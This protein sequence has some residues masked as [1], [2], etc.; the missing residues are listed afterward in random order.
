MTKSSAACRP[1]PAPLSAFA[2][3]RLAA[4]RQAALWQAAFWLAALWLAA[5][6]AACSN[7]SAGFQVDASTAPDTSAPGDAARSDVPRT[8]LEVRISSPTPDAVFPPG[9]VVDLEAEVTWTGAEMWKLDATWSSS[10]AGELGTARPDDSGRVV[11]RNVELG[12]GPQTL[13]IL[14]VA[15]AENLSVSDSVDVFVRRKP[16]APSIRL[17]PSAPSTE[18]PLEVFIDRDSTVDPGTELVYAYRWRRDGEV[19]QGQ[20]E[21]TIGPHLTEK[22]E[23]WEVAVTPLA[24]GVEGTLAR[25]VVVIRNSLPSIRGVRVLPSVATTDTTLRCEPEDPS[26]V[27]GDSVT[28]ERSWRIDGAVVDGETGETLSGEHFERGDRV[29]CALRPFDGEEYGPTVGSEAVV[30]DNSIPWADGVTVTPSQG[31]ASDT[32]TC[33][34]ATSGDADEDPVTF[35]W[36]W[37]LEGAEQPGAVSRTFLPFGASRGQKLACGARP[38]DGYD[39]GGLVR[40]P[41]VTLGNTPPV[42]ENVLVQ[43]ATVTALGSLTCDPQDGFDADGDPISYAFTW[44]V[45]EQIVEGQDDATLDGTAGGWFH[46]D[47][48]VHC[49][50]TPFDGFDHGPS[51]RS[52]NSVHVGNAPPSLAAALIDPPSGDVHTAFRCVANGF[53]DPDPGDPESILYRW[54]QNGTAVAGQV[55]EAY[56]GGLHPDDVLTCEAT[57]FD[58]LDRGAPVVSDPATIIDL[59]P[60]VGSAE[61]APT[62]ANRLSTLRCIPHGWDDPESAPAGYRYAWQV[63]GQILEG[64]TGDALDAMDLRRGNVVLCRV[65]PWDGVQEGAPV[66]SNAVPIGNTPPSLGGAQLLPAFGNHN[67]V[68]HCDPLSPVDLDGDTVFY[69]YAWFHNDVPIPGA[70]TSTRT[71][72]VYDAGDRLRCQLTPSDG[73]ATG[74]PA[75]SNDATLFNGQPSIETVVVTPS[76]AV[77]TNTLTCTVIGLSDPDG[78]QPTFRLN[79]LVNG[80]LVDGETED[81]L[82]PGPFAKHDQVICR[83]TPNDGFQDGPPRSSDPVP[84]LNTIPVIGRATVQGTAIDAALWFRCDAHE[85]VDIDQDP[86][87]FRY[88]WFKNGADVPGETLQI[89]AGAGFAFDDNVQCEVRPHDGEEYGAPVLSP[90]LNVQNTPPEAEILRPDATRLQQ[91]TWIEFEGRVWDI[92][93]RPE[94]LYAWWEDSRVGFLGEA[95]PDADGKVTF[96]TNELE[97][98]PHLVTLH[99][100]DSLLAEGE[101]TV[102]FLVVSFCGE[103]GH[104]AEAPETYWQEGF[105]S[106]SLTR[107]DFSNR[108]YVTANGYLY[109]MSG[110]DN[111][112]EFW[113]DPIA[114]RTG[115]LGLMIDLPVD[116]PDVF[117]VAKSFDGQPLA[118]V[119][120]DCWVYATDRVNFQFGLYHDVDGELDYSAGAV[121]HTA[122]SSLTYIPPGPAASGS[123]QYPSL[124]PFPIG[125]WVRVSIYRDMQT[126]DFVYYENSQQI[127]RAEGLD[128][129]VPTG[130]SIGMASAGGATLGYID[131]CS[132]FLVSP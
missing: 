54:F 77:V 121:L 71:V 81:Q 56:S 22:G 3:D 128:D 79:W 6:V 70:V 75:M 55:T 76:P 109:L 110:C 59:P 23:E 17:E 69:S 4:P 40:S 7:A 48:V 20:T 38:E 86:V 108:K 14:V 33:N 102:S 15:E 97:E 49:E 124:A 52:K 50:A 111:P 123:Q 89:I 68:F 30:I 74:D 105:E 131:D 62:E 66:W 63:N 19:A 98:G 91:Q 117:S 43:P 78:D 41:D 107:W 104:L 46:R 93:D 37:Y 11:L 72:P 9:A 65:T 67:T 73:I 125:E 36:I 27:D 127:V 18:D 2:A 118:A 64:E 10:V 82:R 103:T 35:R 80:D 13:T 25:A 39:V 8:I 1:S 114:A 51:E 5:S 126:G 83:A 47:D 115:E 132:F 45:N 129:R 92:E 122:A 42:V 95:Q 99:V 120:V 96:G 21:P 130:F 57:P 101:A 12:G 113:I 32:Y 87:T 90:V 61:L 60:S 100:R 24:D 34:V 119:S 53:V 26:D 94:D 112:H 88:R 106:G 16:S 84:V 28:Y 31:T 58:G 44:Y 85:V 116:P 29:V